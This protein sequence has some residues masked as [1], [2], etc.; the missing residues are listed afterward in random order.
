M[1]IAFGLIGLLIALFIVA[2][3]TGR[4]AQVLTQPVAVPGAP[5]ASQPAGNARQQ[6]Q[7]IQQQVRQ[8]Y[9]Q[10]MQEMQKQR[11]ALEEALWRGR[12][13]AGEQKGRLL[14][15]FAPCLIA[16]CP[17]GMSASAVFHPHLFAMKN[18]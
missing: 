18:D 13:F 5:A 14:A 17:S 15:L 9:E 6:A 1:R 12:P 16:L 11:Q 3:L 10:A 4:S 7:Q 2:K 8:Q